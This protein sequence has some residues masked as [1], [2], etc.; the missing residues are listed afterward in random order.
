MTRG[1]LFGVA[2]LALTAGSVSCAYSA[3]TPQGGKRDSRVRFV[4]YDPD[5]VV[6]IT[7]VIRSALE[8]VFSPSE[9]VDKVALGDSAEW[10]TVPAKNILFLKPKLMNG[11]TNMAVVT[12]L[13]DGSVRSYNFSLI[14]REG[15]IKAGLRDAMFQVRFQYPE[16]EQA[17]SRK[18]EADLEREG[19]QARVD[20]AL[21]QSRRD[22]PVNYAY[23]VQGAS[24]IAP[25]EAHDNGQV[26][27]LLFPGNE[28]IPA[29]FTVMP[30]GQ[31]SRVNYTVEGHSVVLHMIA[32]EFRLRRGDVVATVYNHGF[33]KD[34]FGRDPGTG[35]TSEKVVREI[36]AP[37]A[38]AK[39]DEK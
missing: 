10:L 14:V 37:P 4:A 25:T 11:P 6:E 29:I 2:L 17:A 13:K 19:E 27:T 20:A 18:A 8:I 5:E 35:T 39:P 24:A 32:P 22:G 38:P 26:T 31:E 1:L 28:P 30:D 9:T 16:D 34:P 21:R 33:D 12:V 36:A 3:E 23:A 15:E 7:G